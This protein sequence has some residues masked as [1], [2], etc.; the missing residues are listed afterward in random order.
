MI[1]ENYEPK[2]KTKIEN[3]KRDVSIWNKIKQHLFDYYLHPNAIVKLHKNC[4]GNK[5]DSII[6]KQTTDNRSPINNTTDE[7]NAER[8]K[9]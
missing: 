9:L 7:T 4:E 8:T 1:I 6:N 2:T 5:I 3:K